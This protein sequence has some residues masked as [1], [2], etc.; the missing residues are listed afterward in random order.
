MVFHM[1]TTINIDDTIMRDLKGL[2]ARERVTMTELIE[3]SLRS[4]LYRKEHSTEKRKELPS[5][6]G[7]KPTADISDRDVLYDLMES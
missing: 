1:K 7:G 2:A 4:F 3:S 6:H 5:F